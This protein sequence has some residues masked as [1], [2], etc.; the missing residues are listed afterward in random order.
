MAEV[1]DGQLHDL[2]LQFKTAKINYDAAVA[3]ALAKTKRTD[4][5]AAMVNVMSTKQ[6]MIAL[7][8]QMIAATTTYSTPDLDI[9]RRQLQERLDTL[10]DHYG[11]LSASHDKSETLRRILAREEE[12]FDGPFYLFGGLCVLAGAALVGTMI[13]H[14]A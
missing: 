13:L 14:K 10:R 4:I 1:V 8:D 7:L 11:E 6:T 3:T 5:E 12:R 2:E 9:K